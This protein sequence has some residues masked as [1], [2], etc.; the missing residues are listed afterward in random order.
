MKVR[1][2]YTVEVDDDY[3]RGINEYYG[4]AGLAKAFVNGTNA[5]AQLAIS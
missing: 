4:D 5:T 3:R 2:C 1:I